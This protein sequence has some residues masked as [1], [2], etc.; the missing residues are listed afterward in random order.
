MRVHVLKTT[1]PN[2]ASGPTYTF[3]K[4]EEMMR[5]ALSWTSRGGKC[6]CDSYKL[7]DDNGNAGEAKAKKRRPA[8]TGGRTT[9]KQS[10]RSKRPG[11]PRN[12]PHY[13]TC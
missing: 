3:D 9:E 1:F 12:H 10:F 6:E 5:F 4:L 13:G 8:H 7:P 11:R 2:G